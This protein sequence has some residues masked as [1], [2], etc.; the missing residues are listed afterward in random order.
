MNKLK[1]VFS[2]YFREDKFDID[3]F[4]IYVDNT[5]RMNI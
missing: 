5:T 3:K 1:S 2:E 4:V